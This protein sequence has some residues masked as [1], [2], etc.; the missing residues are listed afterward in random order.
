MIFRRRIQALLLTAALCAGSGTA[1]P[2]PAAA[3]ATSPAPDCS[4]SLQSLIDAA[5]AGSTLVA[6][7]C[8]FR[9]TAV[10]RKPITLI[11]QAGSEIRGSDVWG[12]GDWIPSGTLWRSN[13]TVHPTTGTWECAAG[14]GHGCDLLAQV[15]IDGTPLVRV[16]GTPLAGQFA[17]DP[18]AHVLLAS[19]PQ[20]HTVEV[21]TRQQWVTG[22]APNVTI[23]G[24]VMRDAGSPAQHGALTNNGFDNWTVENNTFSDAT[25]AAVSLDQ[26]NNLR[27]LGNVI[28][29]SGQEGVHSY[30]ANNLLIDGNTIFNS[31]TLAFNPEW[32][33]GGMK[34]GA[35]TNA[36]I[37]NNDVSGSNGIGIWCDIGCT[38]VTIA[39]NR[40]H[41]NTWDGISYEISHGGVI[42]G[43]AVWNNG[44]SRAVWGFGAGILC[45]NCDTTLVAGNVVAWNANG[46]SVVNQQRPDG[47]PATGDTLQGNTVLVAGDGPVAIGW[48]QDFAGDLYN[49]LSHNTGSGNAVW[50]RS[51]AGDADRFVWSYGLMAMSSFDQTAGGAGSIYLSNRAEG[52]VIAAYGLPPQ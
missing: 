50:Y 11:G 4:R 47:G 20:G 23:T 42:K 9:E 27:L 12:T 15:F 19:D 43:N 46:I 33:A 31:N 1:L 51:A 37:A 3:G 24:F 34:L 48:W 25:G 52:Q 49:P 21:T 40:V 39:G 16:V 38:N 44:Q 7:P 32:E 6:P 5:P 28:L 29:N 45:Q 17:L 35:A 10:I 36:L 22:E 2:S 26:A 13:L 14:T 18:A 8:V 30:R 41:D